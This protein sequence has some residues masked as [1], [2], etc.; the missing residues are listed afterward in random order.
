MSDT[1]TE[2]LKQ[3]MQRAQR[4]VDNIKKLGPAEKDWMMMRLAE[5]EC[6]ETSVGRTWRRYRETT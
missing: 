6:V 1:Q 2:T 5:V 4:I 3:Q